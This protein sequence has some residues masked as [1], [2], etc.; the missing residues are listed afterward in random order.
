VGV[1]E[2][3]QR[4]KENLRREILDAAR[5]LFVTDGFENVTIRK[6]AE[7]IEYSPTTVY[8]YFKDKAELLECIC[9]ET[10]A[11]FLEI[12]KAIVTETAD[13][14]D[15]LRT[16]LRAYVDFGVANPNHYT[17]TFLLRVKEGDLPEDFTYENSMGGRSFEML[18]TL[19]ERCVDAGIFKPVDV[20]EAS[21]ALW[22]A[23]HG[24]TSLLIVHWGFPWVEN[25]DALI[26][27][28]IDT[29]IEGLRP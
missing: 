25:R 12:Q 7:R 26:D 22:A 13:P 14:L 1:K 19:V 23:V 29:N 15:A 3:K 18:R 2:R 6:I 8:L 4:Q 27:R 28:V 11:Q 17:V 24:I 21:Q 9:E 10:F 20:D 5:D 16:G